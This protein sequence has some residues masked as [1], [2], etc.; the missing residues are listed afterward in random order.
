VNAQELIES[1]KALVA[2]ERGLLAM[3]DGNFRRNK[4]FAKLGISADRRAVARLS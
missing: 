1:A 4:R 2:G 3:D